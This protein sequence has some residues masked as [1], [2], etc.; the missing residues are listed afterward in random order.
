MQRGQEEK[1]SQ[2]DKG[3]NLKDAESMRYNQ[4]LFDTKYI[5]QK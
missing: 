1:L 5:P 3:L 2:I 4:H